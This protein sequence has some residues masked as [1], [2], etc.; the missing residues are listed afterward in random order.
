MSLLRS[1]HLQ[2]SEEDIHMFEVF[3]AEE[4]TWEGEVELIS[5]KVSTR[6]ATVS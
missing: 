4:P 6:K 3:A 1:Y 2:Q 5:G